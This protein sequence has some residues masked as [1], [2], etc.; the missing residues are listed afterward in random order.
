MVL[1]E[2]AEESDL[3]WICEE[4]KK[5]S[6]FFGTKRSIYPDDETARKH[7]NDVQLRIMFFMWLEEI[8][9]ALDLLQAC[10]SLILL[11]LA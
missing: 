2:R 3:D 8:K 4:L 5:F 7:L 10:L 9:R 11:I 1:I 6:D